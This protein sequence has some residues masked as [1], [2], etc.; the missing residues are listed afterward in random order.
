[1]CSTDA[2]RFPLDWR[3]LREIRRRV[4]D[5]SYDDVDLLLGA[6]DEVRAETAALEAGDLIV[7]GPER[8]RP[9]EAAL[10]VALAER[11]NVRVLLTE[12]GDAGADDGLWAM[13]ALLEGAALDLSEYNERR[14][15][16]PRQLRR[17]DVLLLAPDPHD[18]RCAKRRRVLQHL[19]SGAA[20]ES[21]A[22]LYT[23][24]SP[25]AVLLR[26]ELDRAGLPWSG[27]SPEKLSTAPTAQV[28][29]AL[30]ALR[31]DR[32]ARRT[33]LALLNA[34]PRGVEPLRAGE[35]ADW[36]RC[37]RLAGITE[38]S[39]AEWV[40]RLRELRRESVQSS[41]TLVDP[42]AP[43]SPRPI[44]AQRTARACAE[45]ARVLEELGTLL[46]AAAR[47]TGLDEL[48][49]WA[50]GALTPFVGPPISEARPGPVA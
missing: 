31:P 43:Q 23:K 34:A 13:E 32:V 19:E 48:S 11:S 21:V 50:L 37:S 14:P 15:S 41:E 36:D 26:G 6:V 33:V 16:P 29:D 5:R 46:D 20:P 10:L 4:R 38:A 18:P 42:S 44:R 25:Y 47:S 12:T 17:F 39:I 8:L 1:M 30:F 3:R 22:V 45:L 24:P 28:L 49:R 27:P 7:Y 9:A 35:V 40:R 2:V